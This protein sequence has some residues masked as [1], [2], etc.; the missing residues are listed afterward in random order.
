MSRTMTGLLVLAA[1]ALLAGGL[2]AE[3]VLIDMAA[4][5]SVWEFFPDWNRGAFHRTDSRWGPDEARQ[6]ISFMKF[7]IDMEWLQGLGSSQ[8]ASATLKGNSWA[9]L[10]RAAANEG[11]LLQFFRITES[12]WVEG[13][14]TGA[15]P[16][17]EGGVTWLGPD[18]VSTWNTPGRPECVLVATTDTWSSEPLDID[19][20]HAV[21]AWADG[22]PNY[23]ITHD[24][25]GFQTTEGASYSSF[26]SREAEADQ[27]TY[28]GAKAPQLEIVLGQ[29]PQVGDANIDGLVDDDDLSLLLSS[30]GQSVGWDRGNFNGDDAVDDD[31]LSL[32]LANWTGSGAVPEPA[33]AALVL[34][35][36]AVLARRWTG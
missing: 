9:L 3:T 32:L 29:A 18:G 24:Q 17:P 2:S 14:Q 15:P 5:A 7:D 10:E 4:D 34:L 11:H 33:S 30:W 28:P 23:G 27:V 19:I 16:G 31:D 35:G 8:I 1:L 22:E 26:W 25:V 36:A 12:D 21:W 13:I 6:M 20:T